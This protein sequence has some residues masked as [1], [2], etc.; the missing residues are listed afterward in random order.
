MKVVLAGPG[1]ESARFRFRQ[2]QELSQ[3]RRWKVRMH[4]QNE[5]R[6]AHAG[7]P[8]E[9]LHRIEGKVLVHQ[10]RHGVTVRSQHQR[11]AVGHGLGHAQG[12]RNA[13]A[14]LHDHLLTPLLGG[15]IGQ[16]ASHDVGHAA[17]A[18]RHDDGHALSWETGGMAV[19]ERER[20]CRRDRCKSSKQSS[21][22]HQNPP[23]ELLWPRWWRRLEYQGAG[24]SSTGKMS[25]VHIPVNKGS[26]HGQRHAIDE[27]G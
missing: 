5:R 17:R 9:V 1:E 13:R 27:P 4:D 25:Q 8:G 6:R 19:H 2:L 24:W 10:P 15:F 23:V 11:V 7:D 26:Y 3:V 21:K 20:S 22:G 12:S 16:N 14:V 18:K